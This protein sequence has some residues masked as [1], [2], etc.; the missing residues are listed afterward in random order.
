METSSVR[1]ITQSGP[2]FKQ[3]SSDNSPSRTPPHDPAQQQE[4]QQH[5]ERTPSQAL[6]D[7][8]GDVQMV[9]AHYV[10]Q[11]CCSRQC[12]GFSFH[13]LALLI[14]CIVGLVMMVISSPN[15]AVFG[16]WS[17]LFSFGVAGFLPAP[18]IK[19]GNPAPILPV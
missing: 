16:L 19:S 10:K 7:F 5:R 17:S 9:R 11:L 18:K 4:Q 8:D 2:Q 13:C 15:S 14:A 6:V 12:L 3:D 1:A